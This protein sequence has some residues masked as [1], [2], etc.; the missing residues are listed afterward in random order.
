MRGNKIQSSK[1]LRLFFSSVSYKL[2]NLF[3]TSSVVRNSFEYS[4][5]KSHRSL[6]YTEKNLGT[7]FCPFVTQA[8]GR[9]LY[10]LFQ[11]ASSLGAQSSK[12]KDRYFL[13]DLNIFH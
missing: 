13:L 6:Q 11:I 2:Q 8:S 7:Y 9:F 1:K 12:K 10:K 4:F 5:K 3:L